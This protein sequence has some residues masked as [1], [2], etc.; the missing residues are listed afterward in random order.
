M[1]NLLAITVLS[2]VGACAPNERVDAF[3]LGTSCDV[4]QLIADC[5]GY[6]PVPNAPGD[7]VPDVEEPTPLLGEPAQGIRLHVNDGLVT[8]VYAEFG[9][10]RC[11]GVDAR[12][13]SELGHENRHDLNL[14]HWR[15]TAYAIDLGYSV[16]R[17]V[18]SVAIEER[19]MTKPFGS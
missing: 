4:G 1:R 9:L 17:S 3:Q 18:C 6:V 13:H 7:Y 19:S 10:D 8:R 5:T 2:A 14:T 16:D 15:G 11:P 12:L